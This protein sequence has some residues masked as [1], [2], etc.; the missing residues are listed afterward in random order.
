MKDYRIERLTEANQGVADELTSLI[1]QMLPDSPLITAAHLDQIVKS[2]STIIYVARNADDKIVG[3]ATLISVPKLE[4]LTKAMIED[5]VVGE[6]N[7]GKGLGEALVRHVIE[8]AKKMSI[9]LLALTSN[10]YRLA[11]NALYQKLG[12]TIYKT[13]YYKYKL[14]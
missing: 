5:V 9:P 7:R 8:Q 4:G 1:R 3:T 2:S 11:A 13:N 12:F 14:D 10:P 6:G